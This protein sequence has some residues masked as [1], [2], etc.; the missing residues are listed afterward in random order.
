MVPAGCRTGA[1][2]SLR[3]TY[4]A[5]FPTVARFIDELRAAGFSPKVHYCRE[6]D[7]EAGDREADGWWDA[8]LPALRCGARKPKGAKS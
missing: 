6:G 8:A 7:H 2:V 3:E 5:R 4:R 1:A